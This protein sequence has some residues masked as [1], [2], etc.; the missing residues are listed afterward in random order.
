MKY[1]FLVFIFIVENI[2]VFFKT[3]TVL[4]SLAVTLCLFLLL[5]IGKI[6]NR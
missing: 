1:M 5:E 6:L 2:T 3:T 4:L